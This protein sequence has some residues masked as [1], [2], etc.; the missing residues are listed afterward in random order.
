[1]E[2]KD[3]KS[4]FRGPKIKENDPRPQARSRSNREI[5]K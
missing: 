2:H 3:Q 4:V 1:M 5:D